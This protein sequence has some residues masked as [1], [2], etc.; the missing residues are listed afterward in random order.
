MAATQQ[1][2]RSVA[3]RREME[4]MPGRITLRVAAASDIG[5]VRARN[6]DAHVIAHLG[7]AA[8]PPLGDV[9][10]ELLDPTAKP[11][12]MAIAD[13]MGGEMAG[14]MA[15]ALAIEALRRALPSDS[16][17]WNNAL[18]AAVEYANKQVWTAGQDPARK[19]MGSTLTV[20]CVHGV[21]AYL[22]EVGD[23]RAYLLRDGELRLL[24]HD[25]SYVQM[26]VD[27]GA[28]KPSEAENSPMKNVLLSAI[29]QGDQVKVDMGHLELRA[30]DTLL[31]CCDGLSNEVA[32]PDICRTLQRR[33]PPAETCATLIAM[34]NAHGGRDNISVIVATVEAA[35]A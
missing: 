1:P 2:V 31:V 26:L 20:V 23:S 8:T 27:I 7:A 24:T 30:A 18:R 17:D 25:Q 12:L 28:L 19:G 11:V 14:E 29:G 35:A 33:L 3:S 34:A 15:S 21:H 22:A 10:D 32:A 9:P 13:G 4:M 16:P 5:R 6:E